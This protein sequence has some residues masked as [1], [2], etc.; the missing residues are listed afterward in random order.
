MDTRTRPWP[1]HPL[2]SPRYSSCAEQKGERLATEQKQLDRRDE[3]RIGPCE[4]RQQHKARIARFEELLQEHQARNDSQEI[5]IPV[6]ERLR[7]E[8]IEFE[9][10]SK[11]YGDRLLIDN[12]SFKIPP[13]A[14]VHPPN[15]VGK[16]TLFG[17]ITGKETPN[18]SV[19]EDRPA[20]RSRTSDHVTFRTRTCSK[21]S[22]A[23][24]TFRRRIRN[25]SAGCRH[26]FK[27]GDQTLRW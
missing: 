16:S 6:G 11:A 18:P 9:N 5:F 20:S 13:R 17:M 12:L 7:N 26:S 1:R 19:L 3:A 24:T 8:V 14:I 25:P 21:P 22:P 27:G 4:R 2:E 23:A 10:V 15:G